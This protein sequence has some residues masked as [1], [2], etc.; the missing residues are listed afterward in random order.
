MKHKAIASSALVGLLAVSLAACGAGATTAPPAAPAAQATAA[1]LPTFAVPTAPAA[2]IELGVSGSGEIVAAQDADLVFSAQGTVA[3]VRVQ[4][5]AM[6]K[7]GDL[8]AILDTRPFEQALH[9]AEAGLL[10]AKAQ[11]AALNDPPKAA[12]AA[13]ARAQL[14]Q[15]QAALQQV[16]QGPKAQDLQSVDAAV[17]LAQANLQSAR[18]GLSQAKTMADAQ[19]HQAADGLTQAQ[20]RYALAQSN[21]QY[22]QDTG[23][24]PIAGKQ[25]DQKTGKRSGVKLTDAQRANYYSQFVQAEAAMHQ[26]EN[27]VQQAVVAAEQARKAEIVGI[28][29][30][31][32]QVAQAQAAADKL[33]LPPDKSQ[34]AAAQAGIAQARA[35]QVR[36]LPDPSDSQKA[37]A[38]SGVA[39]AEASLELARLNREH[40]EIHAPFDG[41]VAEVN[42]DPGDPSAT[43]SQPAI[44]VVDVSELRLEVQLSDVDIGR[45]QV[46]QSAKIFVDSVPDQVFTGKISYIAPT[47]TA[48]GT[49]RTYLV[50]IALDNQ[51][52]LRAGMSARVDITPQ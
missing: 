5:G 49:L 7:K 50:R 17:A 25:K 18:D 11:E 31:E 19:V 10:A 16:L 33:R 39:Q 44:K 26:A 20:A 27:S 6:V 29:A 47:A 32:Q 40:A 2:Q 46:G 41:I 23:E 1:P 34:V 28:Q 45:V 4:E 24:D 51:H 21:W 8:L 35:A 13:A 52:G 22:V 15:A 38:G 43:G 30:A 42:I 36:I 9:Q 48:V 37:I 14:Q 3:E 12:D